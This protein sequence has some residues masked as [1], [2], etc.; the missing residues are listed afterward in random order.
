MASAASG[1]SAEQR[2]AI[3]ELLIAVKRFW[4]AASSENERQT[5]EHLVAT[6]ERIAKAMDE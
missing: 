2:A 6:F 4:L 1:F 5:G 3:L